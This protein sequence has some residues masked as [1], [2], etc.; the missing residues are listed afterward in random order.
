MQMKYALIGDVHSSKEDLKAVLLHVTE[1]APDATLV[2]T[3]DLFEC[4]ISKRL[5]TNKK[6]DN[7]SDVMLLPEGFV[8]MLTFP[9]VIGNQEE[10][11]LFITETEDPLL[12]L[13]SAMPER[14]E[15]GAAEVIHGHQFEWGGDPWSLQKAEVTTALTFYGHS[16]RSGLLRD[17]FAEEKV[18]FGKPYT[19]GDEQTLVN[20]GAVIFDREWVLYDSIDNTI[21]F[22]KA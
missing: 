15:L 3:G 12:G 6:F 13:L 9:S 1:Q 20:V 19:I 18:V 4:T 17:G 10:R 14:M 7:L 5:I 22:M 21:T 11:I 16:H 8:E 2:G